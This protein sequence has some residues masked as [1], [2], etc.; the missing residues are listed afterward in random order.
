MKRYPWAIR[1]LAVPSMLAG[2]AG[3]Q[4]CG[5]EQEPAFTEKLQ[6]ARLDLVVATDEEELPSMDA[7]AAGSGEAG[8]ETQYGDD[9]IAYETAD[10]I[11]VDSPSVPTEQTYADGAT[12]LDESAEQE[13]DFADGAEQL[14]TAEFN[15]CVSHFGGRSRVVVVGNKVDRAL[16]ITSNTIVAIKIT[17]NQ[18]RMDLNL[19]S[20]G[21]LQVKGICVFAAGNQARFN[22]KLGG[23]VGKMV[24]YGRGNR[25]QGNVTVAAGGAIESIYVDLAGNQSAFNISGDGDYTCPAGVKLR[26]NNTST[27]CN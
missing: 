7:L 15:R 18:G 26:G 20:H 5:I 25:S 9:G 21:D 23:T 16:A 6:M 1:A 8:E 27:T 3:L 13:S 4:G 14:T 10:G 24:Y 2:L 12:A 19:A 22:A 11:M 17:G